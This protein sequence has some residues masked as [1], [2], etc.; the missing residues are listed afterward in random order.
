[1][2]FRSGKAWLVWGNGAKH[3]RKQWSGT[4]WGSAV[5]VGDDT[6]RIRLEAQPTSGTFFNMIYQDSS[7]ASDDILE[8]H[9]VNGSTIWSSLF[10]VWAGPVVEVTYEPFDIASMRYVPPSPFA[11]QSAFR[12]RNDNGSESTATWKDTENTAITGVSLTEIIRLRLEIEE[13]NG[14]A[15]TVNARLEFSSDA[16]SCTTGTW[17][18]LDTS[19]TA[20]RVTASGNI[21]NGDPTTNQLTTSAKTFAAGRIFDTQNE[22]TT[23][24]SLNNTHTEWEWAIRGDG[25]ANGT[26]YRF[27]VT[28]AGAVLN[29]YS[30]CGQ[31]TT[32]AGLSTAIEI[33]AQDYTTAVSSI[34]FPAGD[35]E[36]PVYFPTNGVGSEVQTFSSTPGDAKPVVTL[37]NT[38]YNA[39]TIWYNITA[40]SPNVVASENYV[41]IAK[42]GACANPDAISESTFLDGSDNMT[43]NV[44]DSATTIAAAG[45]ADEADKRDLYLEV[46]LSTVAGKT[47]NS[48]LTILGQAL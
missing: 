5:A 45:D 28:D 3:S 35:P 10:T 21:T 29:T 26:T 18:T 39:Y 40:F 1:M 23:G 19:T 11:N 46:T 33:R 12:W 30:N 27:R 41:I 25:A 36:D 47:G 6:A 16:T 24:V 8:E 38:A 42:G 32:A 17:T 20:W 7:S 4:A 2:L 15:T 14:G 37:V 48:T 34:T 43:T 13:T 31:L 44:Y 22:D 9:L